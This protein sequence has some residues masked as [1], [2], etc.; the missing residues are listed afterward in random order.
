M[1][2]TATPPTRS[3]AG[4]SLKL[5]SSGWPV[6]ALQKALIDGAGF[7]L[8][9]DGSFGPKTD[10]AVRT[11]QSRMEVGADGIAG[12]TTKRLLSEAICRR[13]DREYADLPDGLMRQLSKLESGDNPGAV[14]PDVPGGVDCGLFQKRVY[15]PYTVDSLK[16]GFSPYDCGRWSVSDPDHGFLPRVQRFLGSSYTWSKTMKA[17]AQRCALLAH[18]WPAGAEAFA[19]TGDCYSPGAEATWVTRNAD[20][21]PRYVYFLD[22]T[23]VFTRHEWCLFYAMG[24]DPHCGPVPANVGWGT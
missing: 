20:G 6:Y 22:G 21:S 24:I 14:N 2:L 4:A 23:R 10:E 1:A 3:E 16:S 11:Y 7:S 8:S 15:E 9:A 13:L 17:R 12:P 5:G 18:N 19:K